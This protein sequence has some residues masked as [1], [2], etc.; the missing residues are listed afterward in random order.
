MPDRIRAIETALAVLGPT[1]LRIT[2]DSHLHAGHA[3]ARDGGGHYQ[4]EIESAAFAGQRAV[5]R[6]RLVY[7]AIGALMGPSI[8][9]LAIQAWAPGERPSGPNPAM[10]SPSV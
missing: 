3:G 1:Y 5:G 4:V 2:D 9:A 6:H 7:A 8:H 10:P